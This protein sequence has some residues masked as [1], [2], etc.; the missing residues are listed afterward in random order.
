M[1]SQALGQMANAPLALVLAQVRFS[2][3]LTIGKY[4][5]AIQDAVRKRYPIFRKGQMQT[6]EFAAG[7]AAPTVSTSERWDFA[8]AE[9]RERF[10]VQESS[11]VFMATR[12]RTFED[13][14]T[15]HGVVL[16]CFEHAVP[17]VYVQGLGLRYV[18]LI[19]PNPG[20]RPE[21][22]LVEGLHG[23]PVEIKAETFQSRHIA[24]WKVDNGTIVFRYVS[25]ARAPFLP[26]DLQPLELEPSEVM[27]K[28]SE[29]KQSIGMMDSDRMLDY[30]GQYRA[31]ELSKLFA[32]IHSDASEVFR[33]AISQK[34]RAIWNSS[35]A[36]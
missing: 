30:R 19:V 33:K 8:D 27:K 11:L 32:R 3:Y 2:P 15:R 1:T 5:P 26:P 17:D 6:I 24:R 34:A 7:S 20:E 28:A 35:T 4:I 22:Y 18:D 9:N 25:G 36:S 12:Y 16:E 10:I 31:S 23:S 29:S 13:F 14:E 21:D